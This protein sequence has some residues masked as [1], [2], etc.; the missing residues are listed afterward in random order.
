MFGTPRRV[1]ERGEAAA[2]DA[3]Q[4]EFAE[5]QIIDEAV[6]IAGD[7]ARLRSGRIGRAAAP[8]A[9][10]EGDDAVAGLAKV[11]RSAAPRYRYCRCWNATARSACRSR[12]Y[13]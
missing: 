5:F 12:R 8:A 6:E 10:V 2:G 9:P 11:P 13:R 4:M 3:E 7:A 1:I